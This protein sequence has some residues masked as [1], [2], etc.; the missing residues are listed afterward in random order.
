MMILIERRVFDDDINRKKNHDSIWNKVFDDRMMIWNKVNLQCP[1]DKHITT[2]KSLRM[3][4][5]VNSL[6]LCMNSIQ[7]W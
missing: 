5:V 3:S 6:F 2:S 7:N 1:L 4:F